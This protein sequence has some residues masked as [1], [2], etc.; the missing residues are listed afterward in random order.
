MSRLPA[1]FRDPNSNV[2]WLVDG[3][4]SLSDALTWMD[5][6]MGNTTVKIFNLHD[7]VR[8]AQK[9]AIAQSGTIDF[10]AL[11]GHGTG[12]YQSAGAGR[13]YE[14]TGT[15]SMAFKGIF[16]P[17]ESP[18]RGPAEKTISAL[19]GVLSDQATIFL[20]GC[21]VGDGDQGT[22]LLTAISQ[23][24]NGR[25]VQAFENTVW[26]WTGFMVG[27][28]KSVSGDQVDSSYVCLSL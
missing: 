8:E 6:L 2:L 13:A 18:L 12:G 27:S 7:V 1:P 19:N 3:D 16:R 20:A 28:L 11:F 9:F 23:A 21:K 22:G 10:L 5:Q 4:H 26:W 17:G 15:R 14:T 24:L 25:T